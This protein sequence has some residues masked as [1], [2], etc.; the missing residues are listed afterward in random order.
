MSINEI[1]KQI[2]E[3]ERILYH[4]YCEQKKEYGRENVGTRHALASW[5]SVNTLLEELEES[6]I[7]NAIKN[8]A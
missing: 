7:K 3:K 1:L 5:G 4:E 2:Q 6:I 8:E